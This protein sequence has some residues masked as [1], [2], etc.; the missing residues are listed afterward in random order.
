MRAS[1][2]P[3]GSGLFLEPVPVLIERRLALV[4]AEIVRFSA[5]GLRRDG[6]I[7]VYVH[8][9]HRVPRH[10]ITFEIFTGGTMKSVTDR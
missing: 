6:L 4:A 5:E 10:H 7:L 3:A 8:V 1:H 9:T 2:R